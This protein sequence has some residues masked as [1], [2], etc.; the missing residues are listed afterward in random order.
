MVFILRGSLQVVNVVKLLSI[1]APLPAEGLTGKAVLVLSP[2]PSS[3]G[4]GR[5]QSLFSLTLG[6]RA[7]SFM[8]CFLEPGSTFI[9]GCCAWRAFSLPRHKQE[10]GVA[11]Q[12]G[13]VWLAWFPLSCWHM[14]CLV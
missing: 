1:F 14:A 11:R 8:L 10:V 5:G 3:W 9:F 6:E 7:L 12:I 2:L 13:R 4:T